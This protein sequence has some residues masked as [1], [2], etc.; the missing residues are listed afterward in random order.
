MGADD[1]SV[2]PAEI[3]TLLFTDLVGSTELLSR[4]GDDAAEE[5]RRAH[6]GLLREVVDAAGGHE[7]KNLG[8]GLMVVFRSAL[9]ALGCAVAIQQAARNHNQLGVG[10]PFH[11]RVGLHA[12]EPVRD[13]ADYFGTPVV[14]ARRLCDAARGGQIL[15]SLVLVGLIGTRG[16]FSFRSVGSLDLKGLTE[17]VP[18]AEVDWGQ[19]APSPPGRGP[20]FRVLGPVEVDGPDGAPVPLTSPRQ[21]LLLAVLLARAGEVITGDA[22]ADCLWGTEQPANPRAALWSQ[23]S[24]L[25]QRLG[26]TAPIETSPSGYRFTAPD[27]IDAARFG[28]LSGEA[29]RLQAAGDLPAA[30]EGFDAALALWRGSAFGDAAEHPA[31][32]VA[33]TRLDGLRGRAAE[34]RT[35]VLLALGRAAEAAAAAQAVRHEQPF[36]ERPV[37]LH[38]R[39][40]AATGQF[41]RC[42]PGL[43][44]LPAQ[45]GRRARAGPLT[46]APGARSR[47]PP[48]RAPGGRRSATGGSGIA[49]ESSRPP[50]LA[51]PPDTFVGR[52]LEVD[53]LVARLEKGRLVTVTGPGGVGK[54]RLSQHVVDAV[55][56]R[57]PDG[58][59]CCALASVSADEHV[60]S[61]VASALRVE[62]QSGVS[63][64]DRIVDSSPRSRRSWCSTTAN[65]SS[66]APPPSSRPWWPARAGSTCSPRAGNRSAYLAS[67]AC[68][69]IRSRFRW[70]RIGC[71]GPGPLRRTGRRHPAG[72][73]PRRRR[74]HRRLRAVPPGRRAAPG[75]RAGRRA[76]GGPHRSR[77][78]HRDRRAIGRDHRRTGPG[79]TSPSTHA[80]VEWSY[81]L[82]DEED[83]APFE[84]LAVFAGG[85]T[86]DAAAVVAGTDQGTM[87]DRLT[88]LVDRSLVTARPEGATTRYAMLEPIRAYAEHCLRRRSSYDEARHR[89][90]RSFVTFAEEADRHLR[91]LD[92]GSGGIRLLD[93]EVA[94]LRMAHRWLVAGVTPTTPCGWPGRCTGTATKGGRQRYSPGRRRPSAASVARPSEPS[95][96]LRGRRRR[97]LEAG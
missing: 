48:P 55:A 6:F 50:T 17:P 60:P 74:P 4:I 40:L 83:R 79:R 33:A 16:G 41:R 47:D 9:D 39:A 78:R 38:M 76:G 10:P 70:R 81:D 19:D 92:P 94:N 58:V 91:G 61:A 13:G 73:P 28:R 15:A 20:A 22:L 36:R 1:G 87:V 23:V 97:S 14:V 3:V 80:L 77:D 42:P 7:V 59:W 11:I 62:Q 69:S 89:H 26:A 53:A 86:A 8:D 34:G 27:E 88:R 24:R 96:R 18:A 5:A 31:L 65:T 57:Y 54:T 82:L 30:L 52:D 29:Q 2:T 35:E 67:S 43:R 51:P 90:A 72:V 25:R 71:A 95:G 56:G 93:H 12:G 32:A 44:P 85:W 45:P 84:E 63:P 66:R 64:E 21:R 37:E 49:G 46:R 68:H 75:H